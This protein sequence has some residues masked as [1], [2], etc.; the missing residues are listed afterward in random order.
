[1]VAKHCSKQTGQF[2]LRTRVQVRQ[3]FTN[4][5]ASCC[6]T[7]ACRRNPFRTSPRPSYQQ[8]HPDYSE[9]LHLPSVPLLPSSPPALPQRLLLGLLTQTRVGW[10]RSCSCSPQTTTSPLTPAFPAPLSHPSANKGRT[11]PLGSPTCP[12]GVLG[13]SP[14][15]GASSGS[16]ACPQ[17]PGSLNVTRRGSGLVCLFV[18]GSEKS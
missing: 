5:S 7:R 12:E 17:Q 13:A 9:Q 15:L 8:L 1:M 11:K 2:C 14:R 3:S 18:V 16:P 10:G 6:G 4:F